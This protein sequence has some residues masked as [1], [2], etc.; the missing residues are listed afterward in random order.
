MSATF[1]RFFRSGVFWTCRVSEAAK[2]LSA[3]QLAAVN[4]VETAHPF[5]SRRHP[6][7]EVGSP[8][9]S[10]QRAFTSERQPLLESAAPLYR[11]RAPLLKPSR[12]RPDGETIP[13]SCVP[14]L[15]ASV[16]TDKVELAHELRFDKRWSTTERGR[17]NKHSASAVPLITAA[18]TRGRNTRPVDYLHR[19]SARSQSLTDDLMHGSASDDAVVLGPAA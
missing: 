1:W 13:K 18:G 9:H 16:L 12:I 14:S 2:A 10:G 19:R 15:L 5:F 6:E 8:R 17:S 4:L 11:T 3:A 7:A